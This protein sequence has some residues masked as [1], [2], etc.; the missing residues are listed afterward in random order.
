[1]AASL[2]F[3]PSTLCG[4]GSGNHFSV[5][6]TLIIDGLTVTRTLHL[7]RSAIKNDALTGEDAD[8]FAYYAMRVLSRQVSLA[9]VRPALVNTTLDLTAVTA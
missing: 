6:Y 1:L 3:Q 5:E 2:T 7:D 9:N 8:R 4:A